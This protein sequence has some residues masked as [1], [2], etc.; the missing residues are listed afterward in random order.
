MDVICGRKTVGRAT[1]QLLANGRPIQPAAWARAVG[2]VEQLDVHTPAQTVIEALWFSGR[3]RLGRDVS[4]Q[5]VRV[6]GI[7]GGHA[8]V[9]VC[10]LLCVLLRTGT[11]CSCSRS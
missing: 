4:D 8:C 7:G 1:G 10:V 6:A 9:C 11:Q 5:Q 2:Y 3:L